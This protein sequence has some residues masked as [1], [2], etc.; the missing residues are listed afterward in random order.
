MGEA[1]VR[2]VT[3][4]DAAMA[5]AL[6]LE[7]LADTPLAFLETIDEAA[8]RSHAQFKAKF[9]ERVA[10]NQSALFVAAADG[11]LVGQAGGFTPPGTRDV[12][13]I[14]AVYL[15]PAWRG[16]GLLGRLIE[17]VA[18][19]SRA[20]GRTELELEVVVG[21]DRAVRAYQRLGF[22]DTGLRARHPTVPVLTELKMRRTA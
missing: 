18:Q 22:V 2:R 16:S 12:T 13:L 5:R 8:A 15:T 11:R 7:M 19:W 1:V 6:R 21:N 17:A 10:G 20:A 9:S 4:A 3:I 14:Y